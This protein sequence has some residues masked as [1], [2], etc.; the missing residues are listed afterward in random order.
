MPGTDLTY[1]NVV[2]R[3]CMTRTFQT[4]VVPEESGTDKVLERTLIEV[5]GYLHL[6]DTAGLRISGVTIPQ[7][8]IASAY[9]ELARLL[10]VYRASLTY[11]LDG[12]T[13]FECGLNED[14]E[15]GP[16]P[17]S[18]KI[19]K[20]I[21]SRCL[22]VSYSIMT[23][24]TGCEGDGPGSE[25]RVISNRWS[26]EESF[27]S[28]HVCSRTI[29]GTLR[30]SRP[31]SDKYPI[32]FRSLVIPPRVRGFRR[33]SIKIE[34]GR[35]QVTLKY[36]F[37]D[38]M[39][40]AAAP[41]PAVAWECVHTAETADG[42][43]FVT[44]CRVKLTGAPTVNRR[45]LFARCAQIIE[46]RIGPLNTHVGQT[47]I[48]SLRF[49]DHLDVPVVEA[50]AAVRF[51]PVAS[52]LKWF[53]D[54]AGTDLSSGGT[55]LPSY[56]E[57]DGDIPARRIFPA[58]SGY[59]PGIWPDPLAA[60]PGYGVAFAMFLQQPC[61]DEH[62]V[63]GTDAQPS[64]GYSAP[65][66]TVT[67]EPVTDQDGSSEI[68]DSP[69]DK[70]L[71]SEQQLSAM[72]PVYTLDSEWDIE[73][74]TVQVAYAAT[75][76]D[77]QDDCGFFPIARKKCRRIVRLVAERIGAWPEIPEAKDLSPDIILVRSRIMPSAPRTTPMA[78][79]LIYRVEAEYTFGYRKAPTDEFDAG[80]LPYVDVA[81]APGGLF[82]LKISEPTARIL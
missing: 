10:L 46:N 6:D 23:S 1:N 77:E 75:P 12:V 73:H 82:T 50:E 66:I 37:T 54:R 18:L 58:V 59:D 45:A 53:S 11:S 72:Y 64:A 78:N 80:N 35:D 33:D 15:G 16:K 49:I 41:S 42:A 55:L 38:V 17:Q 68:T 43:T 5:V 44:Q 60:S 32:N 61:S 74:N 4:D 81:E 48:Q 14:A 47:T 21:G 39:A 9:E 52:A 8:N 27:D 65:A 62:D 67:D 30:V 28:M 25:V 63:P 40:H 2:I 79:A 19:L 34:Q 13:M 70:P 31:A 51:T 3:N 56:N 29:S 7:D 36:T 71:Y 20:V 69:G 26:A 22:Q 24:K 57:P 76:D